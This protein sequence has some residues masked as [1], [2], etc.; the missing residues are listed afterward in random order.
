MAM[1]TL[2]A[3]LAIGLAI[4]AAAAWG[5]GQPIVALG[6]AVIAAWLGGQALRGWRKR[7]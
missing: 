6:A 7:R 5:G 1:V 4:V 2:F 3:A